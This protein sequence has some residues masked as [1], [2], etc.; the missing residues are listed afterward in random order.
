VTR[1]S[2]RG[3]AGVAVVCCAALAGCAR[4]SE[5]APVTGRVTYRGKPVPLGAVMFVP[6]RGLAAVGSVDAEGRFELHSRGPGDGATLGTHKVAFLPPFPPPPGY[7]AIP[8]RY[9]D[10]ETSGL[11]FEVKAGTPNV[12]D[13][14]LKD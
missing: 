7:P 12:C 6:A 4:D 14:D 10:A 2:R 1:T 11:T 5:L 13:I 8:K 3:W 9:R